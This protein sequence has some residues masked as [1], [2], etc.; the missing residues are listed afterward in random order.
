MD[1]LSF[2]EHLIL[3]YTITSTEN[4]LSRHI[5]A[6]LFSGNNENDIK[7]VI[8]LSSFWLLVLSI[9]GFMFE[10]MKSEIIMFEI[11]K[12]EIIML[13]NIFNFEI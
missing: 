13:I 8:Y 7:Y 6:K 3:N 9:F 2:L 4:S 11:M 12:S 5:L 1:D 10:I